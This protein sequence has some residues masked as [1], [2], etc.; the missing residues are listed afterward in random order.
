[1]AKEK[2]HHHMATSA[3]KMDKMHEKAEGKRGG[4][5]KVSLDYSSRAGKP[6]EVNGFPNQSF[7]AHW[8]SNPSF[9]GDRYPDG[10][11]DIDGIEMRMMDMIKKQKSDRL[12]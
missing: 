10:I 5:N 9:P 4:S 3:K 6:S 1:M 11:D 2:R 8:G 12:Y 7:V